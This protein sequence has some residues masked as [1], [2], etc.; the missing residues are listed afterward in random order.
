MRWP[1]VLYD[2]GEYGT[3]RFLLPKSEA[4]RVIRELRKL[5]PD[6]RKL[7]L[8]HIPRLFHEAGDVYRYGLVR[9]RVCRA[10]FPHPPDTYLI[11]KVL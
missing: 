11:A 1:K 6:W 9:V 7:R 10:G 3:E 4:K 5:G 8:E 2:F